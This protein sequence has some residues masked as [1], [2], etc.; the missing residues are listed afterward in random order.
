MSLS[1]VLLFLKMGFLS[2]LLT[3]PVQDTPFLSPA[4]KLETHG[5]VLALRS[6]TLYF[7]SSKLR[8]KSMNIFSSKLKKPIWITYL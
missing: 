7:S 3:A 6:T 1:S 4:E 2:S 5:G 8:T